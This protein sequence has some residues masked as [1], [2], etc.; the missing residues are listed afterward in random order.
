MPAPTIRA[1][2]LACCCLGSNSHYS[3]RLPTTS[4]TFSYPKYCKHPSAA[5]YLLLKP[6]YSSAAEQPRPVTVLLELQSRFDIT[7]VTYLDPRALCTVTNPAQRSSL[8]EKGTHVDAAADEMKFSRY[9]DVHNPEWFLFFL[10]WMEAPPPSAPSR[11][12]SY[13]IWVRVIDRQ[14]KNRAPHKCFCRL[15]IGVRG[16]FLCKVCV[17]G[18]CHLQAWQAGQSSGLWWHTLCGKQGFSQSQGQRLVCRNPTECRQI[19]W[20]H[21]HL[22]DETFDWQINKE[23]F[24]SISW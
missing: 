7:K 13:C 19:V 22:N 17:H 4:Q 21:H 6:G 8:G 23:S 15:N 10:G 5:V 14:R 20:I 2:T 12:V 3:R 1:G 11:S 18:N 24:A 9:D 16:K